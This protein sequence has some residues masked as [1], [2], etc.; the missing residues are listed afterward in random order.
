RTRA[1]EVAC[2]V[3]SDELEGMFTAVAAG[4]PMK[5]LA[6]DWSDTQKAAMAFWLL[7]VSTGYFD[8]GAPA[9]RVGNA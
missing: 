3:A 6:Q 1:F 8:G 9:D 7:V 4:E 2:G 5:A